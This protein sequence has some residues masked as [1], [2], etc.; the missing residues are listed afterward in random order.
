M[1]L[2]DVVFNALSDIVV[3]AGVDAA[4]V[5]IHETPKDNNSIIIR[6]KT[7]KTR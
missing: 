6:V 4:V 2:A 3:V 1:G 5:E 7:Y